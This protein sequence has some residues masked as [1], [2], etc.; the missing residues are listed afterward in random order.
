MWYFVIIVSILLVG[1]FIWAS[2]EDRKQKK[3]QN[4]KGEKPLFRT[5]EDLEEYGKPMDS[6]PVDFDDA[7]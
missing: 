2:I 1:F 6:H 5:E 4:K 7:E 3:K